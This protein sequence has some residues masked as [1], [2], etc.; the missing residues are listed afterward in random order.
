MWDDGTGQMVPVGNG[1][2]PAVG[3]TNRVYARI[4]N[5]GNAIAS[6]VVVTIEVTDPLGMGITGPA[7]WVLVGTANSTTFPQ[8]ASIPAGGTADVYVDWKPTFALS[9]AQIA[10]GVFYFHSCLR[11]RMNPVAGETVLANQDGDREQENISYFQVSPK[12][13]HRP[14]HVKSVSIRN[15][16]LRQKKNMVLAY[17]LTAPKGFEDWR[18]VLNK[19]VQDVTLAP[20]EL[21]EIPV[22]IIP[23]SSAH[24]P[25]Q[26]YSVD[27][28]GL[29]YHTLVNSLNKKDLHSEFRYTGGARIEGLIV[30]PT[31][32]S[33]SAFGTT[34]GLIS[35]AGQVRFPERLETPARTVPV[36][37]IGWSRK[38]GFI[39]STRVLMTPESNGQFRGA[40]R[41]NGDDA[42]ERVD[43]MF[44]GTTEE[45][46]ALERVPVVRTIAR[47]R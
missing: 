29:S 9:P 1:D 4:R 2:D 25:G 37:A 46:S 41:Q 5:V 10:A 11:L 30:G 24:Q 13:G 17:R 27:V 21:R 35:I 3:Q 23:G 6:N 22:E 32:I 47:P 7:G 28:Y 8:L 36:M 18:V 33:C 12:K 42:V 43:C 19:G 44:A 40:I 45:S 20:G 39:E 16:D 31:N 26:R 14:H 15:D 38:R 34:R